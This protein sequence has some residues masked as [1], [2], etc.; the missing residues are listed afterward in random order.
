M[1]L[2]AVDYNRAIRP[3]PDHCEKS[4][5]SEPFAQKMPGGKRTLD[6]QELRPTK[7]KRFNPELAKKNASQFNEM[8]EDLLKA[9][10]S[11]ILAVSNVWKCDQRD[12]II[13]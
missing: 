12:D 11:F 7:R 4:E 13:R 6:S 2:Y 9:Y 5:S 3:S 1:K 8:K 10:D